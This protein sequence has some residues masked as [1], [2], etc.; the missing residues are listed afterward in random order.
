MTDVLNVK[1]AYSTVKKIILDVKNLE[2]KEYYFDLQT[3]NIDVLKER[4][5]QLTDENKE[6]LKYLWDL[7]EA[8]DLLKNDH[9]E[10]KG[11]TSEYYKRTATKNLNLSEV[12]VDFL[13]VFKEQDEVSLAERVIIDHLLSKGYTKIEV[14]RSIEVLVE[15]KIITSMFILSGMFIDLTSKGKKIILSREA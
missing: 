15:K 4:I 9:N 5:Q 8:Y 12:E 6:M 10:L 2:E 1:E 3:T 7:I 13:K 14:K 11:V